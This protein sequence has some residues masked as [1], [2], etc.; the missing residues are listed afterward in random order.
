MFFLPYEIVTK[1]T[2]KEDK[3]SMMRIYKELEGILEKNPNVLITSSPTNNLISYLF[4]F[5]STCHYE[6]L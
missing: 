6:Q 4:R 5:F 2:Q 3:F 1:R